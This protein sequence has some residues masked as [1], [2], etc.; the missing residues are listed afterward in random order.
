MRHLSFGGVHR[1]VKLAHA[2]Q[3]GC[4]VFLMRRS[5]KVGLIKDDRR[6][7]RWHLFCLFIGPAN[8]PAA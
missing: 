2:I 7:L 8:Q 5:P 4:P 1:V 3:C 6:A